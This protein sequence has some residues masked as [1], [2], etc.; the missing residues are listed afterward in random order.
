MYN[1]QVNFSWD[2][3]KVAEVKRDHHVE[4]AQIIEFFSDPFA[5]EFEDVV[6]YERSVLDI[7]VHILGLQKIVITAYKHFFQVVKYQS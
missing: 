5:V 6:L 3:E 1:R 7:D 2:D 4:F